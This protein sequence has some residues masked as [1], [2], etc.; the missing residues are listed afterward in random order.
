[1]VVATSRHGLE[2]GVE[3]A[4]L[5]STWVTPDWALADGPPD[6]IALIRTGPLARILVE[7]AA[8]APGHAPWLEAVAELLAGAEDGRVR[9]DYEEQGFRI[10]AALRIDTPA[11]GR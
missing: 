9:V 4:R 6:E 7:R 1:M 5:A 8:Q 3:L 2:R 10:R 11:S